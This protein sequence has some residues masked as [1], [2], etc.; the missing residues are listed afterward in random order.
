LS[1]P[2][3]RPRSQPCP[4]GRDWSLLGP[5]DG[6]PGVEDAAGVQRAAVA[7]V[8]HGKGSD[9]VEA[10]RLRGRHEQLA[11]TGIADADHAH[12]VVEYPRLRGDGLDDVVAVE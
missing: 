4:Y 8:E 1:P 9:A 7:V 6:E 3:T 5:F 2:S 12:F 10:R 11:D